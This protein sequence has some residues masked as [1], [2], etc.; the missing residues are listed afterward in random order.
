MLILHSPL[1]IALGFLADFDSEYTKEFSYEKFNRIQKGM[2]KEEV[3][4]ILDEPFYTWN[5]GYEC[6]VY[7]RA[8]P[9][10]QTIQR[11]GDIN[12]HHTYVCF[13]D[14]KVEVSGRN[15]FFN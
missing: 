15:T 4:N 14:G 9:V 6:M 10:G 8:K 13:K 2:I 12:W 5:P 3:L 11:Y 7:S 1:V